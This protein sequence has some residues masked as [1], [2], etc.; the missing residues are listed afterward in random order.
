MNEIEYIEGV[1][2]VELDTPIWNKRTNPFYQK[3][4]YQEI[5]RDEEAVYYC[6]DL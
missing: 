6:K 4:G 3:L 5:R 1:S 2:I